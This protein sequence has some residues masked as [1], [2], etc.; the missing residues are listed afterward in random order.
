LK[1]CNCSECGKL[2][3]TTGSDVCPDCLVKETEEL[4]LVKDFLRN[5]KNVGIDEISAA[6]DVDSEKI[7]KF[8][9]DGR[10]VTN[11][12]VPGVELKCERCDKPILSGRFCPNCAKDLSRELRGNISSGSRS[13]QGMFSR[14]TI[15]RRDKKE[16]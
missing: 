14:D 4:E 5:N 2:F 15:K 11:A 1:L 16:D 3:G 13:G 6:T 10:L 8:I 12:P 9:K 7:I